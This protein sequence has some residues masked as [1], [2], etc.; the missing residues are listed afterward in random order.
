MVGFAK[1][2]PGEGS[3]SIL[4][5]SVAEVECVFPSRLKCNML[6][7][8]GLE[9]GVV[10]MIKV[11]VYDQRSVRTLRHLLSADQF[12]KFLECGVL[13][14]VRWNVN[15]GEMRCFPHDTMPGSP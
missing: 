3:V 13:V 15:N 14:C 9:F 1:S 8:F 2:R 5:E 10:S 6:V 11:P 4:E 12:M 7:Q